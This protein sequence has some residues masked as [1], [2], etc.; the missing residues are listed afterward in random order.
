MP[1]VPRRNPASI[2]DLKPLPQTQVT[3]GVSEETFGGGASAEKAGA[4]LHNLTEIGVKLAIDHQNKMDDT[5]A[6][7]QDPLLVKA[8]NDAKIDILNNYKLSK[9]VSIPDRVQQYNSDTQSIIDSAP[10]DYTKAKLSKARAIYLNEINYFGQSRMLDESNEWE[11]VTYKSARETNAQDTKVNSS[12]PDIIQRNL[13]KNDEATLA[14]AKSKGFVTEYDPKNPDA[15][16]PYLA[17]KREAASEIHVNAIQGMLSDGSTEKAFKYYND[18]KDSIVD[19]E[20]SARIGKL[21]KDQQFAQES[22]GAAQVIFAKNHD[23]PVDA[24]SAIASIKDE[25]LRTQVSQD[26]KNLTI[27]D[28]VARYKSS[29]PSVNA[30]ANFKM[31][32]DTLETMRPSMDKD[33]YSAVYTTL[34]ITPGSQEV[35][36]SADRNKNSKYLELMDRA[37]TLHSKPV[38]DQPRLLLDLQRDIILDKGHLKPTNFQTLLGKTIPE[39]QAEI[40]PKTANLWQRGI[41]AIQDYFRN[42]NV[43]GHPADVVAKLEKDISNPSTKPE[44][45]PVKVQAAIAQT[46]LE[47]SSD[48]MLAPS[49]TNATGSRKGGVTPIFPGQSKAK[50]DRRITQPKPKVKEYTQEDL[51]YTAQK[52]GISVEEVKKKLGIE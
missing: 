3:S 8:K 50:S 35:G 31:D 39:F 22:L 16:Q 23:S 45:I 26:Y 47:N 13:L 27:E 32:G 10:N 17:L 33:L 29:L 51:E 20:E 7:S 5:Y 12:D 15:Y 49:V 44:E 38:E 46:A 19:N 24:A 52:N 34:K 9:A 25:K 37:L 28:T 40:A 14:I 1:T 43:G 21:I 36:P 48:A 6:A 41:K 18:N 4:A 2:E 30:V 42:F 11:N